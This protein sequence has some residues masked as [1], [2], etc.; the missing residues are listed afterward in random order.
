MDTFSVLIVALFGLLLLW[1]Y[2]KFTESERQKDR[3][4]Q[5]A[6]A[7]RI[8]E[9]ED[10][11]RYFANY[12]GYIARSVVTKKEL[13][14]RIDAGISAD[15]LTDFIA[16]RMFGLEGLELGQDVREGIG[17]PVML[18]EQYRDKHLYVIGK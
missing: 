3:E 13:Q 15:E 5:G 4:R 8:S 12:H 14:E 17:I 11:V 1:A 18:P 6:E 2:R 7:R 16:D 10:V 9:C